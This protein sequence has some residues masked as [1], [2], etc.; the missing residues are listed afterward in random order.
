MGKVKYNAELFD[1]L[2]KNL[3][4]INNSIIFEKEDDKVVVRRSD[5]ESTIAYQLTAPKEYFDFDEDQIA[6]YNYNEFHQYFTA[7]DGPDLSISNGKIY[8]KKNTSKTDYLLSQPEQ[9]SPGPKSINFKDPDVR[10]K[11][12]SSDLDEFIKMIGLIK[13]KKAHIFGKG[14]KITIK[15]FNSLHDNTFEK[16]FDVENLNNNDEEIDFV[17]FSETFER[18]PANRDYN[19]E[20]KKQGFVRISLIDENMTL[21]VYTGRIKA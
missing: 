15:I 21:D 14:D 3:T 17:I 11:L 6:F 18:F 2:K 20:I 13:P 19:I 10:F 12:N 9:I 4:L 8:I 16:T 7:L 5:S 1:I